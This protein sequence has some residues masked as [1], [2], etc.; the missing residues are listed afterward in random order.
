MNTNSQF[1]GVSSSAP[2]RLPQLEVL[3]PLVA[4]PPTTSVQV[5]T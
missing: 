2:R 3:E 1:A 5:R 4:G